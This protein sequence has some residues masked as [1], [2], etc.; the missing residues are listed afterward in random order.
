MEDWFVWLARL[1]YLGVFLMAGGMLYRAAKVVI[2]R[3]MRFVAD[4]RGR[5][6]VNPERWAHLVVAVNFL[7]GALLLG[8]GVAVLLVG[9]HFTVWTGTA[10]LVLWSYYFFLRVISN[11]ASR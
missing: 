6:M 2:G 4:W 3:D 8:I 11:R 1:M 9:L 7:G 10:G 5:T